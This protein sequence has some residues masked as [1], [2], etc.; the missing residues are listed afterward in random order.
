MV[1]KERCI[2]LS[3]INLREI[4]ND[5]TRQSCSGLS[6]ERWNRHWMEM[7][8]YR[9]IMFRNEVGIHMFY[10]LSLLFECFLFGVWAFSCQI[11][12]RSLYGFLAFLYGNFY[13][14]CWHQRFEP[15]VVSSRNTP[16]SQSLETDIDVWRS[17]QTGP[18]V[19]PL[20]DCL[21]P[22]LCDR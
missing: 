15:P 12:F 4:E 18:P 17:E 5:P 10:L 20:I 2:L 1:R 8:N 19:R 21:T 14:F 3:F 11:C 7:V 13:V 6:I 9:P 22:T 16:W